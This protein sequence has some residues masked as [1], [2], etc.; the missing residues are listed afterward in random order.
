MLLMLANSNKVISSVVLSVAGDWF[1]LC[2]FFFF[3]FFFF[4]FLTFQPFALLLHVPFLL[5]AYLP[6][7]A[8]LFE[9]CFVTSHLEALHHVIQ[10]SISH[11]G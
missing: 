4:S 2:F 11:L 6:Y 8:L 3:F 5:L 10:S 7:F 9:V 1:D